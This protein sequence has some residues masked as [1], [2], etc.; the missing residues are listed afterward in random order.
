MDVG[1]QFSPLQNSDSYNEKKGTLRGLHFQLP[2]HA[3]AKIVRCIA[4]AVFDVAVD[5]RPKSTGYGQWRSEI[6]SAENGNAL[7]IPNGFA[8]G[9]QTL[10]DHCIVSYVIDTNHA[11]EHVAGIRWSDPEIAIKWPD[12]EHRIMSEK[13]VLLP[14]LQNLCNH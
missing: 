6:L 3:E 2:P 10:T 1:V 5:L 14:F 9:F 11:P 13:D 12:E 7:F 8:H 4:G